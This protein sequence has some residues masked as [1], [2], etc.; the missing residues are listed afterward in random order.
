MRR[1]CH[2]RVR[3][4]RRADLTPE[5][6]A[7]GEGA[8]GVIRARAAGCAWCLVPESARAGGYTHL[9]VYGEFMNLR[10]LHMILMSSYKDRRIPSVM[11]CLLRYRF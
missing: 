3:E 1:V 5:T 6:P 8:C 9:R 10:G 4:R 2:L 7:E 11:K